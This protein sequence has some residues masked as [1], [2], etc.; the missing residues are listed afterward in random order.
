MDEKKTVFYSPTAHTVVLLFQNSVHL[1]F[2][3]YLKSLIWGELRGP[4]LTFTEF[5]NGS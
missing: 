1:Q 3:K 4:V 5:F 2:S